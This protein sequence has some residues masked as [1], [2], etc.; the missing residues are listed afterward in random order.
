MLRNSDG[1]PYKL[2]DYQL[3]DPESPELCLFQEW[4]E[5]VIKQGGSPVFYEEV[6]IPSGAIDPIYREA[7]NKLYA[8]AIQ[9]WCFYEPTPN[10]F[11]QDLYGIGSP[12]EQ[13]FEFNKSSVIQRVGH[14]PKIGS[15]IYT[16]HRRENWMVLDIKTGEYQGWGEL[17]LQLICQRFQETVTSN[18][19]QV[20]QKQPDF[21]L[22]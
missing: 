3:F 7:R 17:R 14:M 13:L 19:G 15:R 9:L 10:Q 16:P 5:A 11:Y 2:S 1:T 22:K 21:K 8:P 18:D 12:D 6:I 4:D 20:T